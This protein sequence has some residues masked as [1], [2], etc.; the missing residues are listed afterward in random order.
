MSTSPTPVS[1][2]A[3]RRG[4]EQ[5]AVGV[6]FGIVHAMSDRTLHIA[7]LGPAP[8]DD[9]GAS[10]LAAELLHGLA[11]RGHRID[12][13]FPSTGQSRP[14]RLAQDTNVTFTWGTARWQWNRWYSS[15]RITAFAS[16]LL[17][18]TLALLRLR[19]RILSA[20]RRD[21]YDVIYQFSYI[22]SPAVPSRLR[23]T[24]PL[25]LHPGTHSAGELKALIAERRL[26]IRCE[27][28]A[29]LALVAAI[30]LARAGAQR[31]LIHRATL[32]VCMSEVFRDH[33]VRDYRYPV[34]ATVVVPNPVRLERFTPSERPLGEPPVVLALGRV[35]ARKGV[36][37]LVAAARELLESGVPARIRVVGGPSLWS[38]YTRLLDDLPP[39][40]AEYV[41]SVPWSAVPQEL[42]GSDVLVQASRYEPF[43]LTVAEALAAGVP[44]VA[45]SEVGAIERVDRSVAAEV[46]PGDARALAA[47]V[48]KM[49]ERMRGDAAAIR[50]TAHAEA[51]RL[52][53]PEVVC[54]QISAA[55]ERL[56]HGD[57]FT[58]PPTGTT[59]GST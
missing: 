9:G 32:L 52:F 55:L 30:M 27:S 25:V 46:A 51:Q 41:G 22:E 49:L 18:R 57:A 37:T 29:R 36:E 4:G 28:P 24:V 11:Q 21:P 56:V 16:G 23:G 48:A 43:A 7:W 20:H 34:A 10:G 38:D 17:V 8:R 3:D 31:R 54:E 13:F 47:A 2:G 1:A 12:C 35:A 5:S 45:T 53:A 19:R 33:L 59:D 6:A 42:A 58:E 15:T 44:V 39:E 14:E 50:A 40:N 26:G